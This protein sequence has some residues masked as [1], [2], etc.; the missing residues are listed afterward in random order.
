MLLCEEPAAVLVLLRTRECGRV[1]EEP[2]ATRRLGSGVVSR[3]TRRVEPGGVA[4]AFAKEAHRVR[5]RVRLD[6]RLPRPIRQRPRPLLC[7]RVVE[8]LVP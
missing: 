3:R 6:V 1:A 7:A 4:V 2:T 8:R 5:R